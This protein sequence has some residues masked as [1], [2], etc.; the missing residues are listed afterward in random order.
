MLL[1][2]QRIM[3]IRVMANA[4]M[5]SGPYYSITPFCYLIEYAERSYRIDPQRIPYQNDTCAQI[6]VLYTPMYLFLLLASFQVP[7]HDPTC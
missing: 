4:T 3:R 6:L 5:P 1:L 7:R 2:L